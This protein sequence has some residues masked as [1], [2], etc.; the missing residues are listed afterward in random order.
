MSTL[1]TTTGVESMFPEIDNLGQAFRA[2]IYYKALKIDT[3]SVMT[4]FR[5]SKRNAWRL[6]G[7]QLLPT[8]DSLSI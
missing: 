7:I 4:L 1:V 6:C 3:S 5:W 2:A 8:S